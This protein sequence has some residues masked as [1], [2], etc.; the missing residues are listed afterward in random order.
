M[1]KK[2]NFYFHFVLFLKGERNGRNEKS[3]KF[4]RIIF[5]RVT[6][7]ALIGAQKWIKTL[8]QINVR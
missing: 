5:I 6:L 3:E 7:N 2:N 8:R 4:N 1:Q